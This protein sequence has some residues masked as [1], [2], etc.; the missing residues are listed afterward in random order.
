VD[1]PVP[2]TTNATVRAV[3]SSRNTWTGSVTIRIARAIASSKK[4]PAHNQVAPWKKRCR[5]G[6]RPSGCRSATT[7]AASRATSGSWP[8]AVRA[9]ST[10]IAMFATGNCSRNSHSSPVASTTA[11]CTVSTSAEIVS[12]LGT[13]PVTTLRTRAVS[14]IAASPAISPA[15]RPAAHA[16]TA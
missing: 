14:Q 5:P 15:S 8:L 9:N 2:V 6:W 10:H 11:A 4:T 13:E 16:A 12:R 1:A 3:E 7:S